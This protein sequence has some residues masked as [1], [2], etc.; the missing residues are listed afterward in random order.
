MGSDINGARN[1][2]CFS[3]S[4]LWRPRRGEDS[5][6]SPRGQPTIQVPQK[7]WPHGRRH[8]ISFAGVSCGIASLSLSILKPKTTSLSTSDQVAATCTN[9]TTFDAKQQH[10]DATE[11]RFIPRFRPITE[12]NV[13]VCFIL[14][15]LF[16]ELN[17]GKDCSRTTVALHP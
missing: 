11:V 1:N 10:S 7:R 2:A 16:L 9:S 15:L 8:Q 14:F 13:Y 4:S 17:R 6:Y 12:K 3:R 5:L